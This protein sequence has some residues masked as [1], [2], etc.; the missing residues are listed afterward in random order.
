MAGTGRLRALPRLKT[1]CAPP[2]G[3]AGRG[4]SRAGRLRR[5]LMAHPAVLPDCTNS[6]Q[7]LSRPLSQTRRYRGG[8]C[9]GLQGADPSNPASSRLSSLRHAS[10]RSTARSPK[11]PSR[12]SAGRSMCGASWRALR[13]AAPALCAAAAAPLPPACMRAQSGCGACRRM[14]TPPMLLPSAHAGS[15]QQASILRAVTVT[16]QRLRRRAASSA[17]WPPAA[18]RRA[19]RR[20]D[21]QA[22]TLRLQPVLPRRCPAGAGAPAA[23]LPQPC[24]C[25]RCAGAPAASPP[26]P[27]GLRWPPRRCSI[28]HAAPSASPRHS[29]PDR[30]IAQR[31]RHAP[32]VR[33]SSPR[34]R[35]QRTA[36]PQRCAGRPH[37]VAPP[38]RPCSVASSGGDPDSRPRAP[39]KRVPPHA[40]TAPRR[41]APID[42]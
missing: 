8:P 24:R 34:P 14:C 26:A 38:N 3:R 27:R 30:A 42:A 19:R 16:A 35:A 6:R 5:A 15:A 33:G 11:S 17:A 31:R 23:G 7:A 2:A 29:S 40:D 37:T 32:T 12:M 1:L 10:T 25:M 21:A 22:S 18:R 28:P 36:R 20:A 39:H 13:A 9:A 41:H 4:S